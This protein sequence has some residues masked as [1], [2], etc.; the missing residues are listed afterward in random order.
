MNYHRQVSTP[1]FSYRTV[2]FEWLI[3]NVMNSDSCNRCE[4]SWDMFR[5]E[6]IIA[7]SP[8]LRKILE[9]LEGYSLIRL[10]ITEKN[11]RSTIRT[12]ESKSPVPLPVFCLSFLLHCTLWVIVI[13]GLITLH[14]HHRGW[15]NS[16]SMYSSA[17]FREMG[18]DTYQPVQEFFHQQ[19]QIWLTIMDGHDMTLFVKRHCRFFSGAFSCTWGITGCTLR[20]LI[21]VKYKNRES[22]SWKVFKKK[23]EL[24]TDFSVTCLNMIRFGVHD[25]T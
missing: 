25:C 9:D 18:Y 23:P 22:R 5:F 13:T 4:V 3:F 10:Y 2:F 6:Q 15:M 11:D 16:C 1:W 7:I 24:E 20:N 14:G 12:L 21:Q 17:P 8:K 19:Y